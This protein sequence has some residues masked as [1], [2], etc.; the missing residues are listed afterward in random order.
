[1][2]PQTVK[3]YLT[4]KTISVRMIW[5]FNHKIRSIPPGKILRIETLAPAIIHWSGDGWKTIHDVTAHE[6]AFG[7]HVADLETKTLAEG[8]AVKFTVY[9][10]DAGHWQGEDFNVRVGS[11]LQNVPSAS[12][13]NQ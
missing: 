6:A 13:K 8:M 1:M 3:L 5:R 2:P 11:P 4:D 12:G 7:M 9:W 10:P